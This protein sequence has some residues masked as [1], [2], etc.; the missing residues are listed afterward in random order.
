METTTQETK[1]EGETK[2]LTMEELK[3]LI[4]EGIDAYVKAN[5]VERKDVLGGDK[6]EAD[7]T[8]KEERI[9]N[10]LKAVFAKDIDSIRKSYSEKDQAMFKTRGLSGGVDADGGF[11]VPD[12]FRMEIL[13]L[14]EQYGVARRECTVVGMKH[15]TLHLP[16]LSSS[17]SVYWPNEGAAITSSKPQF[18]RVTLTAKKMAGLA[19][20]TSELLD[21]ADVDVVALLT[22]LFA[23]AIAKEED[24]QVLRGT[25]APITGVLNAASTNVVTMAATRTNFNQITADDLLSMIDAV[26]AAAEVGAKFYFH[27][28]I[29]T[30]IRRLKDSQGN[31]IWSAPAQGA[32]G[33]IWGYE[34]VTTDVMPAQASTAISTKFVIFGNLKHTIFGDRKAV[35]VKVAEEATVKDTDGVTDID[36]FRQDMKA[37]RVIERIAAAV[38]IPTAYA[39]LRTAAA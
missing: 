25:G 19:P 24:A 31:Y 15:D 37:L 11:L 27:K 1:V 9:S 3:T 29:L 13:R 22:K 2:T 36:L 32:P 35:S 4:A 10:F 21:D 6:A 34:Y 28:N 26:S 16:T 7:A 12:E 30:H 14:I 17:V 38:G 8:S 23:E 18:G 5:N 39:V 33:T 20:V